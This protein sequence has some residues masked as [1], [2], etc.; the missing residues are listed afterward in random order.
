MKTRRIVYWVTTALTAFVFL[1][2]GVVD[3][4]R[5]DFAMEG[6]RALGYPD[7]FASILGVWKVLGGAVILLPRMPRVK[8]WAY[9]GM[10]F[11]LTGAAAS[12]A[13][14]GDGAASVLI[15]LGIALIVATSWWLRPLDRV[16]QASG[17]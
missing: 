13:A 7:Y 16:L 10:I 15:P 1:S 11:D 3:L 14:S 2:G 9:A 5:P 4:L 17:A 12:R 8:E 6:M